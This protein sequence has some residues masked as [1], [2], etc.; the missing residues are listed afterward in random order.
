[1]AWRCA[2]CAWVMSCFRPSSTPLWCHAVPWGSMIESFHCLPPPSACGAFP[3]NE[4]PNVR[5]RLRL[6]PNSVSCQFGVWRWTD[7][8]SYPCCGVP[9]KQYRHIESASTSPCFTLCWCIFGCSKWTA[10]TLLPQCRLKKHRKLMKIASLICQGYDLGRRA[11]GG[12]CHLALAEAI[13][14]SLSLCAAT[15]ASDPV[16]CSTLLY[17][18]PCGDARLYPNIPLTLGTCRGFVFDNVW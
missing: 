4:S 6:W 1:M 5:S 7:L 15:S 18:F 12:D 13:S 17:F 2:E 9:W 3:N 10:A 16:P 14:L 11:G 8:F